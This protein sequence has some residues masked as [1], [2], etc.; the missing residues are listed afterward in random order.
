MVDTLDE[1]LRGRLRV[2]QP[3]EGNRV[4]LDALLLADFAAAGRPRRILDL[5]CGNGVVGLALGL[6][7]PAAEIVGVELDPT[8]AALAR[9]NAE[10]NGARL[11]VVEGD[12][13]R[14]ASLPLAAASF[15]LVVTNPPFHRGGRGAAGAR[16]AARHEVTWTVAQVAAAAARFVKTKGM[17]SLVFPAERSAELLAALAGADIRP[18]LVRPVA[19]IAGEAARRVLVAAQKGYRG[20]ITLAWPLVVHRADRRTFTEE[21]ARILGD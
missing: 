10:L 11:E 5:G 2:Y 17:M 1:L 6:R 21:A 19:S 8:M 9:R 14:P 7:F 18:R 13:A 16:G 4:S 15:D 3:R 12:L 20:G